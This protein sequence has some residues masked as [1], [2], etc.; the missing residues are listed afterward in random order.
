MLVRVEGDGPLYERLYRALCAAIADGR[1]APGARMPST[2]SLAG[3]LAIS[4]TV[5]VAAY[6]Q[7]LGEGRV[8]GRPGSGT[9]VA[10][11]LAQPPPAAQTRSITPRSARLSRYA[12]RVVDLAP[13][14]RAG[15]PG[16][17]QPLP[18][19]FRYGRPAVKE[20]P[21]AAWA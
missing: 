21:Q 1:L 15:A 19:D 2:R 9:Y 8:E 7:L 3:E 16:R 14:P 5:V 4:R 20:F 18:Y 11:R 17:I 10:A 12:R 6:A 13:Y